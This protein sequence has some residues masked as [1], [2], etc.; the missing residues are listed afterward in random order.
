[1]NE[2]EEISLEI[3]QLIGSLNLAAT[4]A[5]PQH[6]MENFCRFSGCTTV[7]TDN[8]QCLLLHA[9]AFLLIL[10]QHSCCIHQFLLVF[11]GNNSIAL[12]KEHMGVLEVKHIVAH[13][14]GLA[15]SCRL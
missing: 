14:N 9:L 10:K 15:M 11:N 4:L 13:N 5:L 1:M 12:G 6:S 2:L 8:S 3:F 7:F